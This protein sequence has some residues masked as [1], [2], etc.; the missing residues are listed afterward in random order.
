[1]K[2]ESIDLNLLLSFD[3]LATEGNVT[4]AAAKRSISQPAMSAAL[5]RLRALFG[6]PLF[7]RTGG[8]M[9][10]TSR[11]RRLAGPIA[12]AIATLREAIEPG[13]AFRPE[14]S[15]HVFRIT[16]SDYVEAILLGRLMAAIRRVAPGV[17]LRTV[18]PVQ[19]FTP[20]EDELRAGEVELALGLFAATMRPRQELLSTVLFRDRFVAL[21][22][23]RHP[24]VGRTLGLKTFLGIPQI[25]V[26][27]PADVG[28]GMVDTVL[29]SRGLE[30]HV[31]LTVGNMVPVPAIV[32]HSDLLGIAPERLARV[33]ARSFALKL[34][35]LPIPMPDL[36][37]TMVWH[38]SRQNDRAQSWLRETI[39]RGFSTDRG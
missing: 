15:I 2:L 14:D 32:A 13:T 29:S 28:M 16:A 10:P 1:M 27:Y 33:W 3:V 30:R 38:E 11:A 37:L 5:A 18:R 9:R 36:P 26:V 34:L 35:D 39:A 24:Q 25:R 17:S 7:V 8:R 4:R 21:V 23:A 6:D 20:P 31:A 19:A 22:R 12:N